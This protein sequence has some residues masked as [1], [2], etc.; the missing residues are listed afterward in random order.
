MSFDL[1]ISGYI[2]L[3]RIIKIDP[4]AMPGK[5]SIVQNDDNGMLEYGGCN[6]NISVD[7]AR[8]GYRCLPIIRVGDDYVSSGFQSFMRT[9][10]ISELALKKVHGVATSCCYLVENPD[11]D[12]MTLYYPGSMDQKRFLPYED[13]WFAE[14]KYALMTVASR[15]DNEAFL[16]MANKHKLPLYLGMK[17]DID[18]FPP[19]FLKKVMPHLIGV[20]A[21]RSEEQYL[22]TTF[23]IDDIRELFKLFPQL[24][25]IVITQGSKGS[26]A[27]YQHHGA[28]IKVGIATPDTIV[29]SVGTGDAY[30]AGYFY[31][32]LQG[33]D[34]KTRI[35]YG[36]TL[37]SFVLETA[38]ATVGKIGKQQLIARHAKNFK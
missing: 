2:S 33:V 1:I 26:L 29:S 14:A 35:E 3:D 7:L 34:L 25:T 13:S 31:G 15:R 5:T 11:G 6:I 12:H 8:L 20:F 4:H 28:P 16:A 18:A 22:L 27:Y 19:D 37:A 32:L 23:G 24:E 30:I 21:N 17:L 38:G 9:N 36:A 10:K